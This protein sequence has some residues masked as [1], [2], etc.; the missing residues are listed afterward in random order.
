MSNHCSNQHG[1]LRAEF[2][3][4][5]AL[6]AATASVSLA[7]IDSSYQF[8]VLLLVILKLCKSVAKLDPP[9]SN[10]LVNTVVP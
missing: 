1:T 9:Q 2:Y 10:S 5:D 3:K 4:P 6:I 8:L 7:Y